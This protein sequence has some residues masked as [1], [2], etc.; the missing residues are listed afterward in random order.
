[1][2][3]AKRA[4][5]PEQLSS[6]PTPRTA[7][8]V[9]PVRLDPILPLA[10][11]VDLQRQVLEIERRYDCPTPGFAMAPERVVD[12]RQKIRGDE[13][14]SRWL[15]AQRDRGDWIDNLAAAARADRGFPKTGSPD[16]VRTRLRE[17]GADGDA[18]EQVDD[19]ERYWLSL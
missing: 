2:S 10:V 17:L 13:P 4:A 9:E 18:F 5:D 6:E 3:Q 11:R 15:L 8:I 16:D 14:F 7:P 1:M 12:E 19:A